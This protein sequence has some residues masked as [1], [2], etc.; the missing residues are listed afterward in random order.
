MYATYKIEYEM[1][2]TATPETRNRFM[3]TGHESK[4]NGL[5]LVVLTQADKQQQFK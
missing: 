3:D 4:T 5:L 1:R 2:L